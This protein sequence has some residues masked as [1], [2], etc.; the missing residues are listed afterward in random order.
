[1]MSPRAAAAS[2]KSQQGQPLV[3]LGNLVPVVGRLVWALNRDADV[4]SL[5]LGELGQPGTKL[6]QVEGSNLLIQVLG[7]HI[8]LLLILATVLLLPQLKL[9]NDLLVS[10]RI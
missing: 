3:L 5:R 4:V 2:R 10:N 8:H 7:E 6:A 1:M 9:S